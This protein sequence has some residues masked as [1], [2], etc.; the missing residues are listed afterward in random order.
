[1]RIEGNEMRRKTTQ[2]TRKQSN[3]AKQIKDL[4]GYIE[5]VVEKRVNDRFLLQTTQFYNERETSDL[6][7]NLIQR[8]AFWDEC[9]PAIGIAKVDA[10]GM[11]R[12]IPVFERFCSVLKE[13]RKLKQPAISCRELAIETIKA[14]PFASPEELVALRKRIYETEKA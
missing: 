11:N 3:S 6:L 2:S 1:M 5:G 13:R 7:A 9:G 8:I 12:L 10:A 4:D 14:C